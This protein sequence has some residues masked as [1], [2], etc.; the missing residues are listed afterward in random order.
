MFGLFNGGF[1]GAQNVLGQMQ[2]RLNG[3]DSRIGQMRPLLG[4]HPGMF[5]GAPPRPPMQMSPYRA[6][7]DFMS[8]AAGSQPMQANNLFNVKPVLGGY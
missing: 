5:G 6:P 7:K 4:G 2:Q 3:I 1:D 8:Y